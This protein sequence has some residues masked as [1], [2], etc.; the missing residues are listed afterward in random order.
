MDTIGLLR[1]KAKK[2]AS[3]IVLPEGQELRTIE[4]AVF[5]SREKIAKTIV[6]GTSDNVKKSLEAKNA[7]MKE[8]EVININNSPLLDKYINKFYELRKHKDITIDEAKKTILGNALYFGALMVSD[9][10]ADGFVAGAVNTTRDVA[11]SVLWCIGL[12]RK[13]PTMSSSFIMILPNKNFGADGVL[14]YAD[15]GIIPFPAPKQLANIAISAGNLMKALFNTEPRIAMLSFS[16][17]GSGKVPETENIINA[18]EIVK[19]SAPGLL[20]DGEI[21]ADA[22]LSPEVARIK[23]PNS[24]IAGCANVLIFPNL[25]AGNISY[26]LTERLAN[27]RALGPL[28]HGLKAPC[29]DLSRGCSWEDIVDVVAV[30]ALRHAYQKNTK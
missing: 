1:E 6:L 4:A 5:L 29:S 13:I 30:T 17:K 2:A 25:E 27:A 18:I 3:K 12:D 28:L 20:I 24:P 15:C 7:D 8:I 14:I 26:K 11:R 10:L 23:I 19:K 21:Q 22:A 16:T 9:G